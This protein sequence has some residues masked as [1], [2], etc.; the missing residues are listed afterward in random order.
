MLY[1]ENVET[2]GEVPVGAR[3][4]GLAEQASQRLARLPS[5]RA[6]I[7]LVRHRRGFHQRSLRPIAVAHLTTD[8]ADV[9]QEKRA[10]PPEMRATGDRDAFLIPP[11]R[12]GQIVAGT[13]HVAAKDVAGTVQH[14]RDVQR[15][16]APVRVRQRR[17]ELVEGADAIVPEHPVQAPQVSMNPAEQQ[18]VARFLRQRKSVEQRLLGSCAVGQ[19]LRR[20]AAQGEVLRLGAIIAGA[21]Q[22][23]GAV[24][25]FQRPGPVALR[26]VG[27]CQAIQ[28]VRGERTIAAL[29]GQ[30]QRARVAVDR[31]VHVAVREQDARAQILDGRLEIDRRRRPGGALHRVGFPPRRVEIPG[32]QTGAGARKRIAG[33]RTGEGRHGPCREEHRQGERPRVSH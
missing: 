17:V 25:V 14:V 13:D 22:L 3:R 9:F 16:A 33:R 18:R 28:D 10:D 27:A 6:H 8:V 19:V 5:G 7:A 11:Q 1:L 21:R 26:V 29:P 24:R 31:R 12:F 23:E 15:R 32:E 4:V 2:L 20:L 30:R